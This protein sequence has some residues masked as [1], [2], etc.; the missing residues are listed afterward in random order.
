M[1]SVTAFLG[2]EGWLTRLSSK[3]KY[4]DHHQDDSLLGGHTRKAT[5][6]D[7]LDH[8]EWYF[9]PFYNECRA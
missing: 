3:F 8:L 5:P 9:D 4:Y 2:P 7:A 6:Q 1:L